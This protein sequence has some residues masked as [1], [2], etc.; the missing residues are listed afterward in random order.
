MKNKYLII[1]II[2]IIATIALGGAFTLGFF[3]NDQTSDSSTWKV[4]NLADITFKIPPKYEEGITQS[5]NV[6]DGVNTEESY[7]SGELSIIINS[8]NWTNDLNRFMNSESA[9]M[10]VLD[11]NGHEIEIFSDN[12]TSQAFFKVKNSTVT[13]KW[14]GDNTDGDI[15]AIINSFFN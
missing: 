1:I 5:E 2:I 4:K 14:S 6:I 8:T 12:E 15:K 7:I 9:T 3:N 11:V 13:I 10:T